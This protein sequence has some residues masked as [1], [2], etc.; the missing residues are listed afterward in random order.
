ML[1]NCL[2]NVIFPSLLIMSN[3]PCPEQALNSDIFRNNWGVI[4]L[5][6]ISQSVFGISW[7]VTLPCIQTHSSWCKHSKL[8]SLC[9]LVWHDMTPSWLHTF[10]CASVVMNINSILHEEMSFDSSSNIHTISQPRHAWMNIIMRSKRGEK[11]NDYVWKKEK[12]KMKWRT[13]GLNIH[14][15]KRS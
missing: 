14:G 9:S 8:D 12:F 1:I 3:V 7:F 15:M 11:R 4:Y 10:K 6:E 2:P 13:G 5:C